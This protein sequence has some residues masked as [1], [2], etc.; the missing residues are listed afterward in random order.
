M[1]VRIAPGIYFPAVYYTKIFTKH[2]FEELGEKSQII[3]DTD[4]Q[5]TF[6]IVAKS[7]KYSSSGRLRR[8]SSGRAT[9]TRST[10]VCS[11]MLPTDPLRQFRTV[12]R[13]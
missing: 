4:L 10:Q 12:L 9:I 7:S 6:A 13:R 3:F 2:E 5:D 1:S 8:I 11:S